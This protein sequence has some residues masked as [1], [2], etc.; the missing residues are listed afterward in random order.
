[1]KD[2]LTTPWVEK[3]RPKSL[4]DVVHHARV[5]SVLRYFLSEHSL[6]PHFFFYGPPGTGKTSTILSCAAELYGSDMSVMVLHLNASDERGVDVVRKQIIQFAAT[7]SILTK[8]NVHTEKLVIL[9]EADSMTEAAQLSLRDILVLYKTR[10][11]LIGNCQY[12]IIPSLQ[13]HFI[14]LV[15]SPINKR[16][17][18]QMGSE[19]LAKE[20]IP[21]SNSA[22]SVIYDKSTGDLRKFINIM[23]ATSIRSAKVYDADVGD[24]QHDPNLV[25]QSVLYLKS[26]T[27]AESVSHMQTMISKHSPDFH[28]WLSSLFYVCLHEKDVDTSKLL[29]FLDSIS[30]I[31]YNSSFMVYYDIQLFSLIACCHHFWCSS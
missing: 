20:D 17:A 4:V 15:F 23:Q 9:D 27:L 7:A 26:H 2:A 30:M 18:I 25:R 19:I 31:E 22:L 1:M 24:M 29:S 10:F 28:S 3:Y 8:K 14:K 12:S 5:L 13:S 6:L 21:H 16:A 11:C